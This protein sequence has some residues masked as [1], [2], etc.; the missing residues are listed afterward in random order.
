MRDTD[1]IVSGLIA[2][3]RDAGTSR[4]C[5]FERRRPANG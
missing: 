4:I 2:L 5:L 3:S 1:A